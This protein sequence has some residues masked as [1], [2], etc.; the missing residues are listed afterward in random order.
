MNQRA[1]QLL[2]IYA[3][4]VLVYLTLVF[5]TKPTKLILKT[6]GITELKYWVIV[7]TAEVLLAIVWAIAYYGY[8]YLSRYAS[9][10]KASS[11]EG[12]PINRLTLGVGV[13]VFQLPITSL[14]S[15]IL[16]KWAAHDHRLLPATTIISHYVEVGLPLIAFILISIGARGLTERVKQ[17]PSQ[18]ATH[19]LAILFIII[20]AL[21]TYLIFKGVPNSLTNYRFDL[22][23]YDLPNW[24]IL[25]TLVMPYIYTCFLGLLAAY[26]IY[27]YACKSPGI[28]YRRS[29]LLL[30]VGL[31]WTLSLSVA[32][33]YITILTR[34]T[35]FRLS[36][37]LFIIYILLILLAVGYIL[38]AWG[39]K[40]LQRIEEVLGGP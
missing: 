1:R 9:T 14:V 8:Y 25:T 35:L 24:L 30:A 38:I 11:K 21:Y 26:E 36:A 12:K 16:N 19:L 6:F 34:I 28:I 37:L 10:I 39:A 13:L 17:R 31:G 4:A 3:L 40:K 18:K 33:Q 5:T 29:F 32:T 7:V 23:V 20:G 27:L 22:A 2:Y 15:E